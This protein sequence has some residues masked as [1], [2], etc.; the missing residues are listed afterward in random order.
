MVLANYVSFLI[1]QLVVSAVDPGR[2][3]LI[4][5]HFHRHVYPMGLQLPSDNPLVNNIRANW[6]LAGFSYLGSIAIEWPFC[7]WILRGKIHRGRSSFYASV[8]AQT[9]S[10]A[11]IIVPWYV[12][13]IH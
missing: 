6:L 13:L 9:V 10:Y 11:L 12:A 5:S 8:V 7:F 2:P 4:A 3:E 1:G